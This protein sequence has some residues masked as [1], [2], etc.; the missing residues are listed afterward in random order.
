M[1]C[2]LNVWLLFIVVLFVINFITTK[3]KIKNI[4]PFC[5][6]YEGGFYGK[7]MMIIA[8]GVMYWGVVFQLHI[9]LKQ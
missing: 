3:A 2:K 4:C 8:V 6:F 1:W 7:A 9:Y 5:F